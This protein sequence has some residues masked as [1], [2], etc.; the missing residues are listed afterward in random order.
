ML[1]PLIVAQQ[2]VNFKLDESRLT[3]S[4]TSS[5]HDWE[6]VATDIFC[7]TLV[8]VDKNN[9]QNIES[10]IFKCKSTSLKSE[11]KLMDSKAYDAMNAKKHPE[12]I[13]N[14]SKSEIRQ[15]N[16]A[17][18]K[19]YLKGS[20]NISGVSKLI[21]IPVTGKLDDKNELEAK[22]SI[23]LKMSDFK[24]EPPTAMFGTITTGNDISIVYDFKFSPTQ[25]MALI[26]LK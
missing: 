13:F 19:G 7:S 14:L 20:L 16:E 6:M 21:M 4:G 25:S 1:S 11:H 15:L 23:K 12:I 22:G 18:F 8:S 2:S 3:V 9:V 24:I 26:N 5:L 17:N 10:V